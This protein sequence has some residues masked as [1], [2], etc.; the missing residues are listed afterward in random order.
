SEHNLTISTEATKAY[1][2]QQDLPISPKFPR[3][4]RP[5]RAV[6][7]DAEMFQLPNA[8]RSRSVFRSFS[9]PVL[10]MTNTKSNFG[11]ES[12]TDSNENQ[13]SRSH[14][15]GECSGQVDDD[16]DSISS[17]QIDPALFEYSSRCLTMLRNGVL[18]D[19]GA[20]FDTG[21][22]KTMSPPS[23][24]DSLERVVALA[25][26]RLM[27][28]EI[29]SNQPGHSMT[30]E[31]E[32]L[33]RLYVELHTRCMASIDDDDGYNSERQSIKK[34]KHSKAHPKESQSWWSRTVKRWTCFWSTVTQTTLR[35]RR[36][37]LSP[38]RNVQ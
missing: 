34:R 21:E 13:H 19:T 12:S 10:T 33:V 27:L 20:S 38:M 4:P 14:S 35:Y 22:T 28:H 32:A 29:L 31:Y 15:S 23:E 6:V 18:T 5:S 9:A 2:Q 3:Q 1:P 8:E 25:E 11:S 30:Q 36:R 17:S 24:E 7:P 16:I 26:L 37:L